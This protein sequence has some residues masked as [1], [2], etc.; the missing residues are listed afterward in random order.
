MES[1]ARR[2]EE[3][4]LALKKATDEWLSLLRDMEQQGQSTDLNYDRYYNAYLDA[5]R[6]QKQVELV[7]FNLRSRQAS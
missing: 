1:E 6:Q 7:L 2:L 3:K 4:H 5:K